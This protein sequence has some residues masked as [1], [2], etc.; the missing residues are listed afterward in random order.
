MFLLVLRKPR[1]FWLKNLDFLLRIIPLPK[2]AS[3]S[4]DSVWQGGVALFC[5]VEPSPF[6]KIC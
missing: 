5:K 3:G 1:G 6:S 4:L 2:L